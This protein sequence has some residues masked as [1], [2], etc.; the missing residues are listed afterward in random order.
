M[1]DVN[2]SPVPTA[3]RLPAHVAPPP[4]ALLALLVVTKDS[5]AAAVAGS[6]VRPEMPKL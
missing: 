4:S 2:W 3:T 6:G 1:Q 5:A